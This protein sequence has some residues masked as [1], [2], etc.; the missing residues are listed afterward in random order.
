MTQLRDVLD[1]VLVEMYKDNIQEGSIYFCKVDLE[2]FCDIFGVENADKYRGV[3]VIVPLKKRLED[4][5]H[6]IVNG[7]DEFPNY[8]QLESGIAGPVGIAEEAGLHYK[9][10]EPNERMIQCIPK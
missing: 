1:L 10:F 7:K 6:R 8:C 2:Y 9:P 3:S 4:S 5:T